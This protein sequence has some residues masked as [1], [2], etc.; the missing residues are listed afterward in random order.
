M[1]PP[2]PGAAAPAA[3]GLHKQPRRRAAGGR[4]HRGRSRVA[5]QSRRPWPVVDDPGGEAGADATWR[6]AAGAGA[7]ELAAV[8][9]LMADGLLFSADNELRGAGASR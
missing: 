3:T 6:V 4:R 8:G 1:A 7:D 5:T 9:M 2:L